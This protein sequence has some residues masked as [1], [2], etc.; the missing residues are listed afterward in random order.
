MCYLPVLRFPIHLVEIRKVAQVIVRA[1][2]AVIG[3]KTQLR[4]IKLNVQ[5]SAL[6]IV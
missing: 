2:G 1:C 6:C 4:P 3:D 5:D